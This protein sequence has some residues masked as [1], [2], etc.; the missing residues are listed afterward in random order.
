MDGIARKFTDNRVTDNE[1]HI[2]N[3][4]EGIIFEIPKPIDPNDD[5]DRFIITRKTDDG[6]YSSWQTIYL[7]NSN[8]IFEDNKYYYRYS[9]PTHENNK[10]YSY[11]IKACDS[12]N[13]TSRELDNNT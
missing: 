9:V 10:T 1:N 13:K 2:F 3:T 8:I 4:R 5:F 12:V 7:N 11:K 6:T